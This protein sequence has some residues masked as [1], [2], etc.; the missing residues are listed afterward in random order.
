MQPVS[1]NWR[2]LAA[3]ML[4]LAVLF[5]IGALYVST[6]V[7][8]SRIEALEH[9][10]ALQASQQIQGAME[11]DAEQLR[12]L[13]HSYADWDETDKFARGHT[14]SYMQSN[15]T[16]TSLRSIDVD[17]IW[18]VN[19]Q[20]ALLAS[21]QTAPQGGNRVVAAP[22][23]LS[24]QILKVLE[25]REPV[26]HADPRHRF[27][28]IDGNLYSL[29]L[30]RISNGQEIGDAGTLVF[31]RQWSPDR[32]HGLASIVRRDISLQAPLTNESPD[33]PVHAV[34]ATDYHVHAWLFAPDNQPAVVLNAR[35]TRDLMIAARHT[36]V[37]VICVLVA[38]FLGLVL[39]LLL[40]LRNAEDE[41]IAHQGRLVA[42]ARTD[43]LTGLHN[44]SM[45]GDLKASEPGANKAAVLYIDI[46]HF[47]M[48]NDTLGHAAGD[49]ILRVVARRLVA[50]VSGHDKVIRMGGDEFLIIAGGV[51]NH[52][53]LAQLAR[54]V[55]EKF[56]DPI[57]VAENPVCVTLS[58]GAALC[59]ADADTLE[60]TIRCADVALYHVKERGRNG[61]QLFDRE[62]TRRQDESESLRDALER[63]V[64]EDL[65]KVDYQ[66]QYDTDS[67]ALIGFEALAR[68]DDPALG[69]VAPT[70][71][72]PLAEQSG[73]IDL[74]GQRVLRTVCGQLA[75]WR[76][77][78]LP[79]KPVCINLSAKQFENPGLADN[80]RNV[81]LEFD[82]EPQLLTFD[83]T[84]SVLMN[85]SAL[86]GST[87][88]QLRALGFRIAID[89]FGT[90]YS[91]LSYLRLMPVSAI[92]IDRS[93]IRDLLASGGSDALVHSIVDIA[94]HFG[95]NVVAEGVESQA[96]LLRL[97]ELR[98][99]AV[100][101]FFLNKPLSPQ[102]C[103]DLLRPGPPGR[104]DSQ[105]PL[106]RSVK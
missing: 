71:F 75:E 64:R 83:I 63:A 33:D 66:P 6:H 90:G 26:L 28:R 58:I 4:V 59:P 92:K 100:Q 101:G 85:R 84:E 56:L 7:L 88:Q 39:L 34:S 50:T 87:L 93:F 51:A 3:P 69:R 29:G 41:V 8:V 15:Y 52:A 38:G 74:L 68:W 106:L 24:R 17:F 73:L 9:A 102:D 96:Q 14:G 97:R 89:D 37:T 104:E 23:D 81:T 2:N 36:I 103:A 42:Q 25:N 40:R 49:A 30:A 44:R 72:I 20:G 46:D 32:L 79:V 13:T 60:K 67:G 80:I 91:S 54:R 47:K 65:I 61:Y 57:E 82:V 62:M 35:W 77:G 53:G 94:R 21:A 31:A 11:Y 1:T 19:L 76:A 12:K 105:G 55:S 22:A 5:G 27:V 95:M 98:C 45:L 10:S 70:H 16:P 43:V 78:G 99:G 86:T 18:I 48:L